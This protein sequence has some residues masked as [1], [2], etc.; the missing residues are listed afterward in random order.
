MKKTLTKEQKINEFIG[1]ALQ[2]ILSKRA[3][4]TFANL[5]KQDPKLSKLIDDMDA[6]AKKIQDYVNKKGY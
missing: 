2:M 6:R 5:Q 1:K 3:S 4:K